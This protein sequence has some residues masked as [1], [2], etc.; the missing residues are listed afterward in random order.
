MLTHS[1]LP[2]QCRL[3]LEVLA[4]SDGTHTYLFRRRRRRVR[5]P[6]GGSVVVCFLKE[7]TLGRPV[8]HSKAG[9]VPRQWHAI[10]GRGHP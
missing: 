1:N 2:R 10:S 9:G 3:Y 7:L 5:S 6:G 4:A 8:A